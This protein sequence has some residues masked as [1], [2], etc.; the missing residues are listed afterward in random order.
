MRAVAKL[1]FRFF[2]LLIL[3]ACVSM[4]DGPSIMALPGKGKNFDQ[5][6]HDD[7]E[8]RH[9]AYEQVGGTTTKNAAVNSGL[10]SAAIGAALGAIAG[11]A[12]GGGHGAAIGAGTGL[13]A[14]GLFGTDNAN[15]SG[16]IHQQRYDQGY[17]QCM[18]AKGHHV[19]VAG[20]FRND[21]YTNGSNIPNPPPP[22]GYPPASVY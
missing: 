3:A 20:T 22:P 16:F 18:Y 4:P 6:R 9:Y 7:Y 11:V 17:I 13:L 2:P 10:N 12:L 21:P 1:I 5:F 19:P 14:G 8:C 15:A